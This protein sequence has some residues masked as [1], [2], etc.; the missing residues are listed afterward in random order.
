[1]E[2]VDRNKAL[3]IIKLMREKDIPYSK[4]LFLEC[5]KDVLKIPDGYDFSEMKNVISEMNELICSITNSN[6]N[7]E[8]REKDIPYSEDLFLE[9][10]KDVL[11]IP[12]GYDFSEMKNVIS[13]MNELICSIT[14]SNINFETREKDILKVSE[15]HEKHG[16]PHKDKSISQSLRDVLKIPSIF[17]DDFIRPLIRDVKSRLKLQA[18]KKKENLHKQP[19]NTHCKKNKIIFIVNDIVKGYSFKNITRQDDFFKGY[20]LSDRINLNTNSI[21]SSGD[22][23][24]NFLLEGS[25]IFEN[26]NKIIFEGKFENNIIKSGKVIFLNGIVLIGDYHIRN[27]YLIEGLISYPNGFVESFLM[28][29]EKNESCKLFF[30]NGSILSGIYISDNLIKG[31]KTFL[32][33]ET[34]EGIFND[35]ILQEGIIKFTC[36]TIHEGK[37]DNSILT[38]GTITIPENDGYIFKYTLKNRMIVSSVYKKV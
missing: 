10:A 21:T 23:D 38:D 26:R 4:D 37:F 12:D 22:H 6:I 5:A 25:L 30:T 9:C 24:S 35:G 33:G 7:F 31:Y 2:H 14:N 16:Y 3:E 20:Y 19:S 13:E 34:Q 32:D 1:M 29:Q 8:T 15:Y 28:P 36:K 17:D 18:T 27:K 11:K